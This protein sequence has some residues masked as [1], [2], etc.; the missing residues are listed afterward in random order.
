MTDREPPLLAMTIATPTLNAQTYLRQALGSIAAQEYGALASVVIDGGSSDETCRIVREDF[1][2]TH[3][4]QLPG[5]GQAEAINRGWQQHPADVYAWLNADDVLLPGTLHAV[6]RLFQQQ[7]EVDILYG[8]AQ[9]INAAGDVI[10]QYPVG[11]FA[12]NAFIR[13]ARNIF[14]QPS[15]FVRG[16]VIERIGW[17]DERLHYVMDWDYWL[18]AAMACT[19]RY[20]PQVFSAMRLHDGAKSIAS[21]GGFAPEI[22]AVYER[23]FAA[24]PP[25][26]F[27]DRFRRSALSAAHYQAADACY[28]AGE[29]A[30]ARQYALRGLR[31][32]PWQPRRIVWMSL[33]GSRARRWLE[34]RFGNPHRGDAP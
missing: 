32:A 10:G 7:P 29:M 1:P 11:G 24:Q 16:R 22:I 15:T 23:F 25:G 8:G 28:W 9:F 2:R 17:L 33:A 26:T 3:L 27:S 13:S 19:I 21:L 20:V 6:N 31:L 5:C 30:Q 4:L 12:R 34:Q 18:K 14:P